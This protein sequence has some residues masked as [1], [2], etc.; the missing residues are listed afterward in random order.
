[1][2]DLD[3]R[4]EMR[5]LPEGEPRRLG[6][7][8]AGLLDRQGLPPSELRPRDSFSIRAGTERALVR[9]LLDRFR[10]LPPSQQETAPALRN[11]LG[12]LLVGA[13]EFSAARAAFQAA[14]ACCAGAPAQAEAL[15]N[16]WRAA[17]EEGRHD[18]ALD[19]LR[20][21]M[22]LC[23]ERFALFPLHRYEPKRVLGAGGFG[24]A[25][26]CHDR[27]FDTEVVVKAL[28][29]DDLDRSVADVFR[30]ARLLYRLSHPGIIRVLDCDHAD[31]A[32][33]QRPYLILDY[34]DGGTLSRHIER[35]GP[36][37]ARAFVPFARRIAEAMKAAHSQ[38]V[39]HRD[40]KP[41][42]ILVGDGLDP[43]I[44]DFGLAVRSG[45]ADG[46][47][48][49]TIL[50]DSLAGTLHYAPPEQMGRLP[51]VPTGPY[52]DVYAFGKTCCYALFATTE[53]RRRQW[54]SI[55]ARLADLVEACI[56][57]GLKE[58]LP[59][60]DAVLARLEALEGPSPEEIAR[61]Q[62]EQMRQLEEDRRRRDEQDRARREAEE[63]ERRLREKEEASPPP[64]P[65]PPVREE[66]DSWRE[67]R[68]QAAL[69]RCK[70]GSVKGP[71]EFAADQ[72]RAASVA[73]NIFGQEYVFLYCDNSGGG[74]KG[75]VAIGL[76]GVYLKDPEDNAQPRTA[77]YSSMHKAKAEP[78]GLLSSARLVIGDTSVQVPSADDAQRLADLV[79]AIAELV[80]HG[81]RPP[82]PEAERAARERRQ[83]LAGQVEPVRAELR[84][85]CEKRKQASLD[86]YGLLLL[87]LGCG[88]FLGAGASAFSRDFPMNWPATGARAVLALIGIGIAAAYGSHCASRQK[89]LDEGGNADLMAGLRR[90]AATIED[91][92]RQLEKVDAQPWHPYLTHLPPEH[93]YHPR[94]QLPHEEPSQAESMGTVWFVLSFLAG[95][96]MLLVA[97]WRKA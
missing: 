3:I 96:A 47:A 52:S 63:R 79:N 46:A 67:Q 8:V 68:F 25:L 61:Q 51:G 30:E 10:A 24:T 19:A 97:W 57:A 40:L 21:A 34:F 75:G 26:L 39:L 88:L 69:A 29:A 23:P 71:T 49:K 13:G 65:P 16:A 41:D 60:F 74:G 66:R 44:I 27:N 89:A 12:K 5:R 2:P 59:S 4:D 93:K 15:F 95:L 11:G 64:P 70:G 18:D 7:A 56:E 53:P 54:E 86:G 45:A 84:K 82:L 78:G 73:L 72:L 87:V 20:R 43:R 36:M 92:L 50:G 80:A 17:L 42:N 35:H 83:Q 62:A 58:R 77:Y 1:M 14:A 94:P 90:K 6:E 32:R 85:M 91:A 55:D 38:G 48:G 37:D 33:Q 9:E 81:W 76:G 28:H 22:K 31:P